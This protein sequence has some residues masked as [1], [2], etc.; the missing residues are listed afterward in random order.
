M[1]GGPARP[2]VFPWLLA[3]VVALALG[4]LVWSLLTP[5]DPNAKRLPDLNLER[6]EGGTLSFASLE[7]E[8][9][10]VNL[11]AT[12]CLPCLRELPL[13]A[14]LDEANPDVRFVFAD[15]GETREK[16]TA[17][18]T[19]MPE[20][21]LEEVVLDRDLD[22]S[23]EFETLGLPVTLFFDAGGALVH[24]HAGE[25]TEEEMEEYLTLVHRGGR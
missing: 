11:W 14:R 6:L 22:L 24:S 21:R 19:D 25:V 2:N 1:E 10:V 20:L 7:G 8:P 3:A 9:A 17:Y 4:W 15:Q 16:V 13:L 18:L 23:L 12:W 5:V